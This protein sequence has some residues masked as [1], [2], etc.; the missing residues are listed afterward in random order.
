MIGFAG[1]QVK[2]LGLYGVLSCISGQ[3]R[4]MDIQ[5]YIRIYWG[6]GVYRV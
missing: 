2:G 4:G 3:R 5:D 1:F 6:I